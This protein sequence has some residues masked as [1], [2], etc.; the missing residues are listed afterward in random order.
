MKKKLIYMAVLGFVVT[1]I[2]ACTKNFE[3]I[4]TNPNDPTEAPLTTV[5]SY[6]LKDHA[7]EFYNTW[8]DMNEPSTYAGHLAKHAYIDESRYVFR[9]NVV[10]NMWTISSRELKNLDIIMQRADEIEGGAVNMKAVAMATQGMIWMVATDRWRD[11]P[12]T[13]ALQ[14]DE[15]VISPAY[16][17]QEEIY[18]A[19]LAQLKE[20]ATL[21][22]QNAGDLLGDG[23]ILFNG[24]MMKWKRFTNSLRLRA[25]IRISDVAPDLA[26]QHIEEIAGDPG[27]Y[28]VMQSNADNAF[29]WWPGSAPYQEPW[30]ADAGARDDYSM[31]IYL[32]DQLKNLDDPRLSVYA[33]PGSDGEYRGYPIGPKEDDAKGWDD[34]LYSRIG[35]RFRDNAAGFSPFMRASEVQF[36]LAEAAEKG[37]SVGVSAEDAYNKG[38]TLSLEENEVPAADI[39]TYLA[40][41]GSYDGDLETIYLQKWISLFKNGQEAWAESRRTD[42]PQMDAADGSPYPGHNRPPFRYPYPTSETQ[43][44]EA[45]SAQ[46]VAEVE[47]NFWGKQMWWDT[48]TGVQ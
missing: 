30:Q 37:W 5:L 43:L 32:I 19:I 45:N 4:N 47:D 14:G 20:A 18:P 1:S 42:V 16:S 39:D 11:L 9:P 6:V 8:G 31:G 36:I 15:G 24:D 34:G 33:K 40:G 25:A 13:E 41:S 38:V 3:D 44:N 7:A 23:D 29:I 46:Y 10:E 48:R 12:F 28:P 35:S 22:N 26:R 17:T 27:T 2:A 21:M